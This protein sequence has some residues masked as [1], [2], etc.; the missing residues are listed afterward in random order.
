MTRFVISIDSLF[1]NDCLNSG[2]DALWS[3]GTDHV[4]LLISLKLNPLFLCPYLF[5]LSS[6]PSFFIFK[7][8]ESHCLLSCPSPNPTLLPCVNNC[9]TFSLSP[10]AGVWLVKSGGCWWSSESC[11]WGSP[12]GWPRHTVVQVRKPAVLPTKQRWERREAVCTDIQLDLFSF[13][14]SPHLRKRTSLWLL[15]EIFMSYIVQ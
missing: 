12:P 3:H 2:T 14:L 15:W 13:I 11:K 1:L 9:H 4:A 5:F 6:H 10:P 7:Q 8:T